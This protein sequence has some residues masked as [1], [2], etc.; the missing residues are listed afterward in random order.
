MGFGDVIVPKRSDVAGGVVVSSRVSSR[1]VREPSKPDV[2]R[3][4]ST[5]RGL[6]RMR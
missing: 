3:M 6:G 1:D 4:L 2:A 5:V